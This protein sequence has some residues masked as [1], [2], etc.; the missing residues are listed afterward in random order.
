MDI[1]FTVARGFAGT[2]TGKW[3]ISGRAADLGGICRRKHVRRS[4]TSLQHLQ[5]SIQ[6]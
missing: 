5:R 6:N 4:E 3:R 1:Q 2:H